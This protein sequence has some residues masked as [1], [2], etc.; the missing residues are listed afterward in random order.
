MRNNISLALLCLITSFCV[1]QNKLEPTGNVGIGTLDPKF[2]LDVI[3]KGRFKVPDDQSGVGGLTI[4]THNGTNLK[5]GGNSNYS[6]IQSHGMLPLYINELGN[7]TIFN[8]RDGNVGI[9]TVKPRQKFVVSN[10]GVEGFEVYLEPLTNIV[11]L[12]SFNRV[13]NTYSK[14][15]LDAS[16]FSFLH[17]NVGIGTMSPHQKFVVSNNG[18]EGLEV[19]LD[20][21]TNIVGLQSFNRVSYIYSKMQLDASQFSFMYGNVGIGTTAPDEKLTV[22]GKI[23]TQEVRVDL[24]GP[25]VPDY[26]FANDYKLKSLEE[27]ESFIKE[28]SHLPE[29][30]SAKEI[31][32]N[33][34]MLAEMNMNLLKKIEELTLYAINQEKKTEKLM[35]YI[36]SQNK[37]LELL[38]KK[39]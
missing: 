11:G 39:Q 30:P 37:R 27:V 35:E 12:Q 8:L 19:Y 29:I 36:D 10:N 6:W 24:A 33:G 18:A 28:N 13:S 25:L 5:I 32:K 23:H 15:Q 38:E 4:E 1:A 26:V 20:P 9:G 16:Q 7:N 34:L 22:K 17:G 21:L 14:M 2:E 3:G 31:E